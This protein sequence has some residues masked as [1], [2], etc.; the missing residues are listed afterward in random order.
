MACITH[1]RGQNPHPYEVVDIDI[2]ENLLYNP[3][4]IGVLGYTSKT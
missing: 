1:E 4:H 3:E 2:I